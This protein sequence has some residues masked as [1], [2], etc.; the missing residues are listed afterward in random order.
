[1]IYVLI[2]L[3]E[4]ILGCEDVI[5]EM[6]IMERN[7][8]IKLP[9]PFNPRTMIKFS[10]ARNQHVTLE[11]FDSFGNLIVKLIDKPMQAGEHRIGFHAALL[12][13]GIYLYK[14]TTPSFTETKKCVLSDKKFITSLTI[15][16][17]YEFILFDNYSLYMN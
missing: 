4:S 16:D 17:S 1:M 14:L 2:L 7:T 15:D 5:T 10:L 6:K 8:L 9:N 3:K 12:P 11:V 13:S